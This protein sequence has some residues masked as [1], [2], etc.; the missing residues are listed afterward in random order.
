[1]TCPYKSFGSLHG[2]SDWSFLQIRSQYTRVPHG[3]SHWHIIDLIKHGL[4]KKKDVCRGL[5]GVSQASLFPR[6]HLTNVQETYQFLKLLK[7]V[8]SCHGH[9]TAR[10]STRKCIACN[11][12]WPWPISLRSFKH[13][14]VCSYIFLVVC[15]WWLYHHMLTVSYISRERWVL[16]SVLLCNLMLFAD[17]RG[18]GQIVAF[19]C[20]HIPLPH[21]YHY[22]DVSGSIELLK[23]LSVRFCRV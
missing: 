4:L 5:A 19:V 13:E 23:C 22:V 6:A 17:N 14:F 3:P 21:Y 18:H 7:Y 11:E 20:L 1:M 8:T 12:L 2:P 9:S 15:L 16:F 10:E